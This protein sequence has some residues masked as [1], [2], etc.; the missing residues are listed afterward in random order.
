[1]DLPKYEKRTFLVYRI[2]CKE[3]GMEYYGILYNWSKRAYYAASCDKELAD[4]TIKRPKK[5]MK[6][7]P[8]LYDDLM[9]F[10]ADEFTVQG[11]KFTTDEQ[12][13]LE[14]IEKWKNGWN[15]G[16]C[17]NNMVECNAEPIQEK[18]TE[19]VAGIKCLETGIIYP[20]P[21]KAAKAVG[22]KDKS[23]IVKVLGKPD[24]TAAKYHWI[25]LQPQK[26]MPPPEPVEVK[27]PLTF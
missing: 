15:K 3:T 5:Y 23:S 8:P 21:G 10:G 18:P 14:Y 19:P 13:A 16:N 12:E 22:L 26:K 25:K 24:R 17:Y 7:C 2:I 27:E 1:M 20:T 4:C 9:E 11:W 6:S